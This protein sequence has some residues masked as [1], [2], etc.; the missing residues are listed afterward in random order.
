MS[1][2]EEQDQKITKAPSTAIK[3]RGVWTD[4][5]VNQLYVSCDDGMHISLNVYLYESSLLSIT[6]TCIGT[7][8]IQ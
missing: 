2:I 3:D 4:T 8:I 1:E 6:R 7:N 5:P